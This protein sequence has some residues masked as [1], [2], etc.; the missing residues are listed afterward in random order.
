MN[1]KEIHLRLS[2]DGRLVESCECVK[3]S[4][5]WNPDPRFATGLTVTNENQNPDWTD[6]YWSHR[7][8]ILCSEGNKAIFSADSETRFFVQCQSFSL[9][10]WCKCF[11]SQKIYLVWLACTVHFVWLRCRLHTHKTHEHFHIQIIHGDQEVDY[12]PCL[13]GKS[14]I[15]PL[16]KLRNLLQL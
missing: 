15:A 6:F 2:R 16:K 4:D 13:L 14:R 3:D 12:H 9:N 8:V 1:G 11:N 10:T 7:H 5:L